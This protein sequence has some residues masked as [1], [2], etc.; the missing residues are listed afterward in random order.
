[1]RVAVG[2]ELAA[3]ETSTGDCTFAPFGLQI[4][5]EG[6]LPVGVQGPLVVDLTVTVALALLVGSA[7]LVAVTV[8]VPAL[9]GAV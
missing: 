9:P 8:W 3:A 4:V 7:L 5:T 1:M 2:L 6:R